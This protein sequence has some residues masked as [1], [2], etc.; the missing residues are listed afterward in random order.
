MTKNTN[1]FEKFITKTPQNRRNNF[2]QFYFQLNFDSEQQAYIRIVNIDNIEIKLDS[3]LNNINDLELINLIVKIQNNMKSSFGWT[4]NR[5]KIFLHEHENIIELLKS[6]SYFV[7]TNFKKI[8][9]EHDISDIRLMLEGSVEI[10][11]S[12]ILISE[13]ETLFHFIAVSENYVYSNAKFYRVASLGTNF[14]DLRVLESS[15][16]VAMLE[17]FLSLVFSNF[18]N[19]KVFYKDYD[20]VKGED[21]FISPVL[22]FKKI[23]EEQNLQVKILKSLQGVPPSI[24]EKYNITKYASVND[25]LKNISISRVID[26]NSHEYNDDFEKILNKCKKGLLDKNNYYYIQ[27][28]FIIEELLTKELIYKELS[29]L[30]SKYIVI[31]TENL[32]DIKI[33][34]LK[35]KLHVS[36]AH[37]IDFLEGS[38]NI[39]IEG[40]FFDISSFIDHYNKN[41]SITLKDGTN[42]IIN[43]SYMDKL[44]R[45]FKKDKNKLKISFFD[46]PLIEELIEDHV[47]SEVFK[48]S[49][50][51]IEGFNHIDK[52]D[53]NKDRIKTDLR[54][55]QEQGFKW[56][57]YLQEN[58][59]GGCLADDMGLGKT[60]QTLALFSSIYPENQTP[61]LII[62]PKSL[63]FNWEKEISRFTP[64]ITYYSFYGAN[65]NIKEARTKN[66]ILTTYSMLRNEIE[67]FKNEDFL[68]TVLDESQ[69]IKTSTSQISRAVIFLKAKYRVA[70]SGTPF[71]NN[72]GELYSLFRFLNPSMF[73]T[74]EDFNKYYSQ[75]IQKENNKEL[76]LELKRKVYPFILRRLKKDVLKELPDK[77]EQTIFVEMS[78]EQKEFYEQRR[79]FYYKSIREQISSLGIGRSQFYILQALNELRQIAS[80]PESK[81]ND[82]IFSPKRE[83]LLENI[84]EVVANKHKVLVFANFLSVVEKVSKDLEKEGI[85]H[86]TMTGATTNRAELVEKFQNDPEYKVFVMTLKTGGLGLNLTSADYIFI[87]DPWW[88]KAA[89]NQAIDRAHRI[90]QDKTVFSYKLITKDTIEEKMLQLQEKKLE[91]FETIIS[92]DDSSI[93]S[94]NEDDVEYILGK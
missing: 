48:K 25:E 2:E 15:F 51:I 40:E 11:A 37:G 81:S 42:V 17:D 75:P 80:I 8:S 84:L 34:T 63:L 71:E 30:S 83:V 27:D 52:I 64:E 73:G 13:I 88:N 19:I 36:I 50:E 79:N 49:R 4:I 56:L 33:K 92:T 78:P 38:G 43:K 9:F 47:S 29:S 70:L 58:E 82:A 65:R 32:S 46:L 77:I 1:I 60:V 85:K 41:S 31:G 87:F 7:D 12:I 3:N 57:K 86:L 61:S 93:K 39:E 90:G 59:L 14:K 6:S 16:K 18:E 74:I 76:T 53:F 23:D 21:K 45:L 54:S 91:L 94:L 89:E 68:Y 24:F 62:M 10:E 26:K 35:P 72:L 66:L 67:K 55:Y 5:N 20:V 44:K 22:F 69:N 28:T